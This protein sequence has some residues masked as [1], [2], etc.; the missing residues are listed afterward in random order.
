MGEP[1]KI[2]SEALFALIRVKVPFDRINAFWLD[3]GAYYWSIELG[4]GGTSNKRQ[5]LPYCPAELATTEVRVAKCIRQLL[6]RSAGALFLLQLLCQDHVTHSVRGL[7]TRQEGYAEGQ[8]YIGSQIQESSVL[9]KEPS[10][11]EV[12][13]RIPVEEALVPI[14]SLDQFSFRKIRESITNL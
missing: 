13:D 1:I 5:R 14:S 9:V 10:D 4:D 6:L 8:S 2:I 7:M 3:D 11:G 12:M